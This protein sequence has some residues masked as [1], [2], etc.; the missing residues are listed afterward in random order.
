[1]RLH[2]SPSRKWK[3]TVVKVF[4][5][6]DLDPATAT[7]TALLPHVLRHGSRELPSLRKVNLAL[8]DLFGTRLAVDVVKLGEQQVVALRLDVVG[9]PFAP[10]GRDPLADALGLLG[11]LLLDPARDAGRD[12]ALQAGAVATERASLRRFLEGLVDDK[13]GYAAERCVRAMCAGEPYSTFEYGA[14]EDLE[15]ADGVALE[16]R[17]RE[18]LAG[19]PIDI[20]LCGAFEPADA[21]AAAERAF[22]GLAPARGAPRALRGTTPH[23]PA[24][25]PR[26]LEERLPVAQAKLVIGLRSDTVLASPGYWALLLMNGVL[27]G[28]PHSRLFKEVREKAALAYDASSSH[29]RLKGLLFITCGVDAANAGRARDLCL[30]QVESL[31]KGDL[32]DDELEQGRLA[33]REGYRALLDSPAQLVNLDYMMALGG[34]SGAPDDAAEALWRV[35]KD[36]VVAAAQGLRLDTTFVLAPAAAGAG[37]AAPQGASP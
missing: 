4:I 30:A 19:A 29:E 18:L 37:A 31:A 25:A 26:E 12:D 3:T 34:R 21:L 20:Y 16:A 22:A 9:A 7:A 13:A 36:E 17:R 33:Y 28:F 8:E 23:P 27:G 5:R 24:R 10:A 11:A 35:T 2:L 6:T 1:M 15:R 32:K 14:L